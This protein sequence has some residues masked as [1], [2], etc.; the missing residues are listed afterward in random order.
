M[1]DAGKQEIPGGRMHPES[2]HQSE[3]HGA[4]DGRNDMHQ[5]RRIGGSGKG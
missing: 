5:N 3:D 1:E 2:T 4:A